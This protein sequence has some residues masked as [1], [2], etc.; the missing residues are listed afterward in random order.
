M[1]EVRGQDS[2]TAGA[3]P[4]PTP[5]AAPAS[6][7]TDALDELL[8]GGPRTLSARDLAHRTGLD[9]DTVRDFWRTLG[10]PS[11]GDDEVMFTERD[12]RALA[13]AQELVVVHGLALSTVVTVIRALGHTSD[14]LALWQVEALVEDM[15]TRYELDDTSARLLV[16]DRLRDLAPLLEQQLLHSY[17]RQLAAVA[18]R[19]AAEFGHLRDVAVD[20][21]M[22]PLARAVGF[23]DMVSF[24]RRTAGLGST[25]LS[26]F[27][28]RFETA[29]RD[30]VVNAGGRVVKTIGDAV[31]FIADSPGAGAAIAIGLADAFGASLD[32]EAARGAGGLAEGARG[33]TPVRVGLVWGRVLSRFGDVFGPSVNLAARLTDVA[34]PSTVLVDA[35]TAQVLSGD[36][37]FALTPQP[38]R[39]LAGVGEV[40][41]YRL[42]SAAR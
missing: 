37:R 26:L 40:L 8:L 35:G 29:A 25:D 11:L 41:P 31:L 1:P 10:L 14:R 21:T 19:Y 6:G 13:M 12:A 33:V 17:R 39:D 34:E 7:T 3:D 30:V 18:D 16:L 9:L 38:A 24:T 4:F 27:V 32:V 36:P 23:A 2:G 42:E 28:Q 15:A 20:G 22:L 5:P